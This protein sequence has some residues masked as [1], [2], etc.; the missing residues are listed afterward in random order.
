MKFLY[1]VFLKRL[2]IVPTHS[3]AI[4]RNI[5]VTMPDG[6]ALLTDVYF[7]SADACR[8][9]YGKGAF[10]A[11]STAYPLA[12][13]GFNVVL[14]CCRGTQGSTGTFD[15]HHDEQRDGLATLNWIKQQP[16]CNGVLAT[17]GGSYLGYTQWAVAAQAGSDVKAMAMQI[18]LSDFSQMTYSGNSLMLQNAFSWS[19]T[20]ISAKKPFA[21]ARML[22]LRLRGIPAISDEQWKFLP[23]AKLDEH[24][25][26]ES[27]PFWKDWM[28]HASASDPWWASMSHSHAANV[29]RPITMIAGWFDIFTPWQM[30]D[31]VAL[32]QA[33]CESRITIGPWQHTDMQAVSVGLQDAVEWF[34]RHLLG[35]AATTRKAVRLFVIGANEWREFDDW[36]PRESIAENWY[37]QSQR[38]L[39]N[40]IATDASA[41]QYVYDP[42][43]P[44]PSLGGPAL[45]ST[46]YSV[47]NAVLEARA[48]VLT[49]TSDAFAQPR[50]IVGSVTA[51]VYVS[52]SAASADF[53]VRLCDVDTAG[54]AK[55]ICDG[56]QRISLTAGTV[57][58]VHVELWPT[59]YRVAQGHRLRVQ[60]SSGAFPRWARNPGT[61]EAMADATELRTATQFIHHAAAHPSAVVIP[62]VS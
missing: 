1:K 20:M 14:Q 58:R 12:S 55:N 3:V 36:P 35:K 25:A 11:G 30:K 34:N 33:G 22:L 49:Y 31:F 50:D 26:G 28:Q 61:N 19:H 29:K 48:D 59:A 45:E 7:G 37:L 56:L 2:G 46:P 54:V 53:F 40:R 43:N 8:S 5:K 18:T 6:V 24:V 32:R 52:S 16:W 15:P 27:I 44:T 10:I 23:L 51:D 17:H 60:I 4:R 57:Q 42:A 47:D 62:F 13:Q 21:F 41:D 38:K 39:H 9:P